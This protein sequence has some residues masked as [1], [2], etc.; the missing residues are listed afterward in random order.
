MMGQLVSRRPKAWWLGVLATSLMLSCN[1]EVPEEIATAYQDL[2]EQIDFNYNVKPILSDKCYHCHGP[3][4]NTRKANFRL[5]TSEGARTK[6]SNGEFAFVSGNPSGSEAIRRILSESPEFRMPPVESHLN[7][8]KGE[9][10]TLYKWVEQGAEWKKHWSF[11]PP[12]KQK[13]PGGFPRNWQVA[14]EIDPFIL[15]RIQSEG[16]SPS[17]QADKERLLRRVTI[18]LTGLPPTLE[19]IDAFV[20]DSSPTA[21]EKVVDRLLVTDAHAERLTLEWLDVAR[22]AD[23]H[24]MHAD[25]YRLM[26]PWRD[27]VIDAFRE[28]TPYD[29]FVTTQLAGDLMPAPTQKQILATAFNRNHPMTDEGGVIDEEFRLKYV[30]DRTITTGTAFLAMTLECA[31]CHDHKFDP[32]SQK[33]FYQVSAFF[34]NVKELGMTGADGNYGPN[35]LLTDQVTEKRIEEIKL[36]I[37]EKENELDRL[38]KGNSPYTAV[39]SA[40]PKGVAG[41]YPIESYATSSDTNKYALDNNPLSSTKSRP[42]FEKGVGGKGNSLKLTGEYDELYLYDAGYF[43]LYDP[44]SAGAWINTSKK[45]ARKTQT[46]MGNTGQKNNF[47]RGWDFFLDQNNRINLRLV[48]SLPHNYLHV[49]SKD[50][51]D[52]NQWRHVMF[53]Y[54]GSAKAGGVKLYLDGLPVETFTSFD[55]LYKTILPVR[56]GTHAPEKRPLAVGKSYRLHTGEFGI[57]KGLIDEIYIFDK[58]LVAL[59]VSDIV[60]KALNTAPSANSNDK[61]LAEYRARNTPAV[62]RGL[63]ELKALRKDLLSTVD[64][65]NEVMVM[66]EMAEPRQTHVLERGD[67]SSL[68]ERVSTG[69]PEAILPFTKDYPPNRLGLAQWLFDEEN[70]LT[71]RVTVNRY[72]QMIFG[73][74]L[75]KTVNDFGNQGDL[76]S[77]PELLDW[78]AVDFIESGWDVRSLLK[79]MVMSATYRQSS[80]IRKDLLESD[81]ENIFLARSPSYRWQAEIIRD[82]ALAAS[83]LLTKQIGGPSVKPYQPDGLWTNIYS[84]RLLKYNTDTGADLYRRSMYTFIRRTSPPPFMTIFDA[85]NRDNCTVYRERTNTPLQALVLLNDPQFVEAAKALAVRAFTFGGTELTGRIRYA[86]RLGTSRTPSADEINILVTLYGKELKLFSESKKSADDLLSVGEYQV[87]NVFDKTELA[88]MTIVVNTILNHDEAYV[89]R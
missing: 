71:A 68:G 77:H 34:N 78:L 18:D 36:Y 47:W 25:G 28:N 9:I 52:V 16:L 69:T 40:L 27:W 54:D 20:S 1:K 76:P 57:F 32:L 70:P 88:A 51:I 72:W 17:S 58:E 7:L 31:S 43:E 3:D 23:S 61:M 30:A 24:G 5:D 62:E 80:V 67:Y 44:F 64:P 46:I 82:N 83:G 86:F 10:A 89:K 19:E 74:G 49:V 59:E 15:T 50:S 56:I 8:T 37:K 26:W 11:I 65:I 87:G 75:V 6:L 12:V 21:Y 22:Y 45:E 63:N 41:H 55:K 73:R 33:E 35:L 2:P 60:Q 38:K 4:K 14:N 42:V 66:E 85:P 81:P 13:I 53:T 79:K 29:K 84:R 48:H 39:S